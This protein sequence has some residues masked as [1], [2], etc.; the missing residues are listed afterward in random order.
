MCSLLSRPLR[1]G[2]STGLWAPGLLPGKGVSG[3]RGISQQ[4][5]VCSPA[6]VGGLARR[7]RCDW[8][9]GCAVALTRHP[10][11]PVSA[12]KFWV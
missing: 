12:Q 11:Y 9:S 5:E 3:Y 1:V 8:A 2:G 10:T 4:A 7:P 6:H